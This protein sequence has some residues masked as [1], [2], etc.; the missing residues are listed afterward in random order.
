MV[1]WAQVVTSRAWGEDKAEE[2]LGEDIYCE[3]VGVVSCT[4]VYCVI[5][6]EKRALDTYKKLVIN[7][8]A[9]IGHKQ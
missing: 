1:A 5:H 4:L 9:G 6:V 2:C 7:K 8:A 3:S